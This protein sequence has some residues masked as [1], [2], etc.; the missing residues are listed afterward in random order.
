MCAVDMC[1]FI[2]MLGSGTNKPSRP[3][4]GEQV[5][6]FNNKWL[7]VYNLIEIYSNRNEY[8]V[9]IWFMSFRMHI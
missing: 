7:L 6:Y 3:Q 9:W 4:K 2:C 5:I 8:T 1:S